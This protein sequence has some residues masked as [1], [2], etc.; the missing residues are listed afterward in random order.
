MTLLE[1]PKQPKGNTEQK[2]LLLSSTGTNNLILCFGDNNHWIVRIPKRK[3]NARQTT[4]DDYEKHIALHNLGLKGYGNIQL[5]KFRNLTRKTNKVGVYLCTYDEV[6]DIESIDKSAVLALIMPRYDSDLFDAYKWGILHQRSRFLITLFQIY[7]SLKGFHE[8]NLVHLDLKPENILINR[9]GDLII[10]DL[11]T[12]SSHRDLTCKS[13]TK[14]TTPPC[15]LRRYIESGSI[16]HKE[17]AL[18]FDDIYAYILII[19]FMLGINDLN[20][21]EKDDTNEMMLRKLKKEIIQTYHLRYPDKNLD[22]TFI[23]FINALTTNSLDDWES[24][25]ECGRD[26]R[27]VVEIFIQ[28]LKESIK[29]N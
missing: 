10:E 24:F 2:L 18:F 6:L 16:H 3:Y 28:Q 5:I 12:V 23:N 20:L 26:P 29:K 1:K 4:V 9:N 21:I 19:A 27:I 7:D 25:G 22:Q 11:D 13:G 14:E 17:P 15:K 8:N